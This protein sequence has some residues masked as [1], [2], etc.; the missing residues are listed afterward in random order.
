MRLH[1][2]CGDM[3]LPGFINCD[4]YNPH[5]QLKCDVIN[6]PFKDNSIEG[7]YSAHLIEHF[8]FFQ[9]YHLLEEWKRVLSP[10]GRLEVETPN[11]EA[12]CKALVE[13][14][15]HNRF[16]FYDQFFGKPWN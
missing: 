8:D 11:L 7:I 5:A 4:L 13:T 10:G 9:A 2:G 6:L 3:I 14:P 12:L 16:Y 1:L 15:E